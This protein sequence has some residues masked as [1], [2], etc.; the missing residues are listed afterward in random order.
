M[1]RVR[2]TKT[3]ETYLVWTESYGPSTPL[4]RY[5]EERADSL[6][7]IQGQGSQGVVLGV[8][9]L[10]SPQTALEG[11]RVKGFPSFLM[12]RN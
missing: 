12:T 10:P 4:A 11:E 5:S 3:G 1:C 7:K 6:A 9:H 8:T 2:E